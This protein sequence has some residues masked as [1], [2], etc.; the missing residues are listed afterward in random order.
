MEIHVLVENLLFQIESRLKIKLIFHT[1]NSTERNEKLFF[2]LNIIFCGEKI[3]EI[4]PILFNHLM[5]L[6]S[7]L[8]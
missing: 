3:L 7:I 5:F 6:M 2:K 1:T 4:D 8:N